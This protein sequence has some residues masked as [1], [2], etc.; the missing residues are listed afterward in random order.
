MENRIDL[1]IPSLGKM[2]MMFPIIANV[3]EQL[4]DYVQKKSTAKA[5][6]DGK[7]IF[8]RYTCDVIASCAFGLE[9]TALRDDDCEILQIA[10][11]IFKMS[12]WRTLYF[13][14]LTPFRRLARK[15]HLSQTEPEV[16]AYFMKMLKETVEHREKNNVVRNDFLQLLMQLK[17]VGQVAGD[18]DPEPNEAMK[19]DIVDRKFTFAE[20]AAQAFIFFFAGFET[21]STTMSFA[22]YELARN[23][24]IQERL[25]REISG[26][27]LKY[28][29]KITYA[30]IMEMEYLDRVVNGEWSL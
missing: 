9:T 11:K 19:T 18:A 12:F 6:F 24:E 27:M 28:D 5:P 7:D 23:E 1:C 3:G 21:S 20:L 2:K 22:L 14:M 13:I 16:T 30:A 4:T 17:N 29:G 8:V 26:V 15:L 25:R 10:H